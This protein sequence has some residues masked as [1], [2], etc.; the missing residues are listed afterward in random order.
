MQRKCDNEV[1]C[2]RPAIGAT[3]ADRVADIR[4]K[5]GIRHIGDIML[6]VPHFIPNVS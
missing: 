1:S 4:A 2:H 5:H 3:V 6:S